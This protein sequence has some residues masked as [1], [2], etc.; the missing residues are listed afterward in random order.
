MPPLSFPIPRGHTAAPAIPV[1]LFCLV[2]SLTWMA[3]SVPPGTCAFASAVR[4]GI[5]DS[6]VARV[7]SAGAGS[8][9]V[10]Q[11]SGCITFPSHQQ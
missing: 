7:L 11:S 9:A 2:L 4:V 1:R 3:P 6:E 10:L 8:Q 5:V